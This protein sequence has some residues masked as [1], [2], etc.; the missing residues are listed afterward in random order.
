VP[1]Q[2]RQYCLALV[3]VESIV[4][5]Y[6]LAVKLSTAL[7]ERVAGEARLGRHLAGGIVGVTARVRGAAEAVVTEM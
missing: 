1:C 5:L 3:H 2:L 7:P 6:S 4:V